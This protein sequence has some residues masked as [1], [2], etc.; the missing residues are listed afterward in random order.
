MR[1]SRRL[2]SRTSAR[3]SCPWVYDLRR[4]HSGLGSASKIASASRPRYGRNGTPTSRWTASI[5]FSAPAEAHQCLV[6]M[7]TLDEQ[8]EDT[9]EMQLIPM[10][11]TS[12]SHFPPAKIQSCRCSAFMHQKTGLSPCF[13]HG[14]RPSCMRGVCRRSNTS[15]SA[16]NS[17]SSPFRLKRE[18][19][20]DLTQSCLC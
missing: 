6:T 20:N 1:R 19:R 16:E 3:R 9:H 18:L 15:S 7:S 5:T 12:P 11:T 13:C 17:D 10:K 14:C 4:S 8:T 2:Q